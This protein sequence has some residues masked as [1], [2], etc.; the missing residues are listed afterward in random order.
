M[1][2]SSKGN[3]R[4]K[5]MAEET[6]FNDFRYRPGFGA[7]SRFARPGAS[8]SMILNLEALSQVVDKA[9]MTLGPIQESSGNAACKSQERRALSDALP[10]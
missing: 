9:R 10:E 1:F 3:P 2:Y 4:G 8:D 5:E 7:G 6:H